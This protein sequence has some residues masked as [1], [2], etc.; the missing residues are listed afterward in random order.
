MQSREEG[1]PIDIT[2]ATYIRSRRRSLAYILMQVEEQ[3]GD[4]KVF[5][6]LYRAVA[7]NTCMHAVRKD[8]KSERVNDIHCEKFRTLISNSWPILQTSV[9]FPAH[10]SIGMYG[11]KLIF[12]CH[13]SE[14]AGSKGLQDSND[15]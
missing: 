10:A 5:V 7:S 8:F 3:W 9:T 4:R 6:D 2:S 1:L 15:G 12:E 14:K 13:I 11:I